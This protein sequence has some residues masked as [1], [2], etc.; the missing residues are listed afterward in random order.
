MFEIQSKLLITPFAVEIKDG[1]GYVTRKILQNIEP[2]IVIVRNKLWVV[3]I[4]NMILGACLLPFLHPIFTR[5]IP[6]SKII[7]NNKQLIIF[8]FSQTFGGILFSIDSIAICHDLQ[9]HN[10]FIFNRWVRISEAYLLR[11]AKKIYT[12]SRRDQKIIRRLYGVE[13]SRIMIADTLFRNQ[14]IKVHKIVPSNV[15]KIVFLGNMRRQQNQ[16]AIKWFSREVMS[17]FPDLYLDVIG[18]TPINLKGFHQNIRWNGQVENLSE[19]LS[20]FELMIAPMFSRAGI[21]VKVYEALQ[22]GLPVLGTVNAFSGL[23]RPEKHF[24]TNSASEWRSIIKNGG[25]FH[26]DPSNVYL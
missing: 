23:G 14:L 22:L 10:K 16:D 15:R 4:V 11:R 17:I 12:L 9:C 2:N 21:K 3:K 24:C 26:Y 1:G 25:L 20:Q 18:L 13:E 7:Q 8:N 5:Y 6:A 19:S